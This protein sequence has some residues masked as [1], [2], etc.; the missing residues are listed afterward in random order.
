MDKIYIWQQTLW[1]KLAKERQ[2]SGHALLLKGRAGIGK[3]LFAHHLAKFLLCEH[4]ENAAEACGNCQS[5]TWF[6]YGDHPNFYLLEPEALSI[7]SG[8]TIVNSKVEE[9]T[10]TTKPKKKPSQQISVNQIRALNDFV[11]LSGHQDGYRVILIRPAEAMNPAAANALLK[12]LEEPPA[13]VLFILVSH[14]PQHLLPTIRS[15]CHQIT[16]PVPDVTTASNWLKQQ[17]IKSPEVCLAAAGF[18]PLLAL[19][20]NDPEYMNNHGDFIQQISDPANFNPIILAEK[21]QRYNLSIVVSWLQKWC[22]DLLSF[23]CTGKVRYHPSQQLVIQTLAANIENKVLIVFM[24][25]LI[26]TQQLSKHPLNARL[27]LEEMLLSYA[28]LITATWNKE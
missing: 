27:F 11:Y 23:R 15:R 6:T 16:M 8:D 14:C 9:D 26:S 28:V 12:K 13:N 24:R 2:F 21:M 22:Y 1:K 10:R 3:S 4:S 18:A 5:C 19:T 20:F 25:D 17:N 7:L